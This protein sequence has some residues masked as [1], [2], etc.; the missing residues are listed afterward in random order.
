MN[1]PKD[2][3]RIEYIPTSDV[4][5]VTNLHTNKSCML[6]RILVSGGVDSCITESGERRQYEVK[7]AS[8][9]E[10]LMYLKTLE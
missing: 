8:D 6:S 4:F 9:K 5:M 7:P 10:L 2:K 3:F 1:L